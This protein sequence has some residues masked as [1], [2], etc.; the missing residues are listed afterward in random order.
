MSCRRVSLN[1]EYS[2]VVFNIVVT[3]NNEQISAQAAIVAVLGQD[4]YSPIL[5][6]PGFEEYNIAPIPAGILAVIPI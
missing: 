4:Q 3:V 5:K 1:F 2:L 6:L